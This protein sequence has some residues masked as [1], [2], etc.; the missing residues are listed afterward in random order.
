MKNA[1]IRAAMIPTETARMRREALG[2]AGGRAEVVV[3][4]PSYAGDL[5]TRPVF[6]SAR[7]LRQ[8][9]GPPSTG[10]GVRGVPSLRGC[11]ADRQR[12]R[13]TVVGDDAED[14]HRLLQ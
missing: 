10:S 2:V 6:R 14:A 9:Q 3:T 13:V 11:R 12:R 4:I 8:P 7:T 1:A 5:C